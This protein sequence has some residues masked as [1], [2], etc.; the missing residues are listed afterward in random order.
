MASTALE[1]IHQQY[2]RKC[3]DGLGDLQK[4]EMKAAIAFPRV[5]LWRVIREPGWSGRQPN[6]ERVVDILVDKMVEQT[7]EIPE[8]VIIPTNDVSFGFNDFDLTSLGSINYQPI[9]DEI[10][11]AELRTQHKTVLAKAMGAAREERLDDYIIRHLIDKDDIDYET[12]A[13]LLYKLAGQAVDH[14]KGYLSNPEDQENVCL[15]HGKKIADFIYDQM[16]HHYF[17]TETGYRAEVIKGLQRCGLKT[18]AVVQIRFETSGH[19]LSH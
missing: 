18:S 14:I 4:P 13:D 17:E 15:C 5:K 19:L 2:E 1:I 16:R 11:I 3:Q 12:N 6:V 8:I 9:S 10:Q 7:I